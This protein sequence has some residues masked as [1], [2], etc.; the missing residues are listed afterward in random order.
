MLEKLK[1]INDYIICKSSNDKSIQ[2]K[3]L[4]IRKILEDKNCFLKMDIEYSYSIL[5]D[6]GIKENN[7]REVYYQLIDIQ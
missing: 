6:L 2:K 4:L 7:L 1:R 3:H 5:R